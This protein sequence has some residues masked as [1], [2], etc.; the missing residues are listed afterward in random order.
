LLTCFLVVPLAH[1]AEDG[2]VTVKMPD[3][4]KDHMRANMRDHLRAIT[5]IQ[6]PLAQGK[7][8]AAAD[9]AERRL[10]MASL[11]AHVASHMAAFMPEEMRAIGTAMHRA[12]SRFAIAAQ[13]AGV[14]RDLRR[15]LATLVEVATKCVACHADYRLQ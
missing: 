9:I 8:D 4:M 12:A 3:M 6:A 10:G 13:D 14:N 7:Y 15:A 2:R 11:K 5:E 1:A